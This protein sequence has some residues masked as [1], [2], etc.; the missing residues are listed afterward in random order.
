MRRK[1]ICFLALFLAITISA[2]AY[3]YPSKGKKLHYQFKN[4]A[5]AFVGCKHKGDRGV[6]HCYDLQTNTMW[7]VGNPWLNH[8]DHE[9]MP[10]DSNY[11]FDLDISGK[12]FGIKQT[13]ILGFNCRKRAD[14]EGI[15]WF[16]RHDQAEE[17]GYY[18]FRTDADHALILTGKAAPDDTAEVTQ[19]YRLRSTEETYSILILEIDRKDGKHTIYMTDTV[20]YYYVDSAKMSVADY[21]CLVLRQLAKGGIREIAIYNRH[22]SIDEMETFFYGKGHHPHLKT[23]VPIINYIPERFETKYGVRGWNEEYL[24][25]SGMC[26]VLAALSLIL[27]LFLRKKP[28]AYRGKGWVILFMLISFIVM[29]LM[30]HYSFGA[31]HVYILICFIS[32]IIVAFGPVSEGYVSSGF[33]GFWEALKKSFSIAGSFLGSFIANMLG[34][35]SSGPIS[36]TVEKTYIDN[37]GEIRVEKEEVMTGVVGATIG[38]YVI[39]STIAVMVVWALSSWIHSGMALIVLVRFILNFRRAK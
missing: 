4:E 12:K 31:F 7:E 19:W 5:I 16:C 26:L 21:D 10:L 33:A 32:Y 14:A 6:L 38:V 39:Y 20:L 29:Q 34:V 37:K 28:I 8:H 3:D 9:G 11:I 25:H 1:I 24:W 27:N 36:K 13:Y 2:S 23:P 18:P 17:V 35:M 22:L 30:Y 15:F